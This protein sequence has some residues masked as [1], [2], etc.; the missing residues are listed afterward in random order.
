MAKLDP[1]TIAL[2]ADDVFEHFLKQGLDEDSHGHF[3]Q[4]LRKEALVT[5]AKLEPV[6]LVR[7]L[8]VAI[9]RLQ[10]HDSVVHASAV[11]TNA[12]SLDSLPARSKLSLKMC[13]RCAR[14][15]WVDSSGIGTGSVCVCSALHCT[16]MRFR[17]VRAAQTMREMWKHGIG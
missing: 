11:D 10:D 1:Q 7:Y 5:L 6:R 8:N 3:Y 4:A 16:G 13:A 17:I 9:K 15:C 12:G 2:C 14:G